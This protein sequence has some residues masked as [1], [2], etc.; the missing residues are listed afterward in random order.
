MHGEG[1]LILVLKGAKDFSEQIYKGG[2]I[3]D[4]KV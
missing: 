3:P 2:E 4:C 1:G